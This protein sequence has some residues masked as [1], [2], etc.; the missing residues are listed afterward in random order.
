VGDLPGGFSQQHGMA[1]ASM[2]RPVR[3]AVFF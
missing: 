2:M 3:L 1:V